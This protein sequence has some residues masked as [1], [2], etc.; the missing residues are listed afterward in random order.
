MNRILLCTTAVAFLTA[1]TALNAASMVKEIEVTADLTAIENPQAATYWT[2]VAD[3]VEN[4][5]V[6]RLT[7]RIADDGVSIKIDLS[8]VELSN[9][10]QEALNVA[11]TK[12]V[13]T[14]NVKP[15]E[16]GDGGFNSYELTVNINQALAFMPEGTDVTKLSQDSKEYYV[17]MVNAF[18]DAV[19]VRLE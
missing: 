14:V 16:P 3:D 11:D 1:A 10:F 12:M 5:I 13:G 6:A 19:V 4:A 2:D 9:S 8:E 15:Q 7:N 17:A 18:A